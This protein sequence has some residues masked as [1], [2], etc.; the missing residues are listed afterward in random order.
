MRHV[1]DLHIPFVIGFLALVVVF[2]LAHAR[3]GEG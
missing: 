2:I 1:Y 3:E